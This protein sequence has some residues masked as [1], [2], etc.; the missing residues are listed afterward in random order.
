MKTLLADL[1][2]DA[3]VILDGGWGTQLYAAGLPAGECP[4]LWNLSHAECVA[5]V[6]RGYVAA[7]SRIILT[8]T[9]RANRIALASYDAAAQAVEINRAGASIS[10]AAAGN[11]ARV[12]GSIGPCGKMLIAREVTEDEVLNAFTEQAR[13]LADAGVDGIVI[14]TMSSLAEAKLA[15]AAARATDLPVVACMVFDSGK[16]KDRTM[17]GETPEQ[18]AAELSAAGA[19]AIGANCG[20]GIDHYIA[21]CRRFH[22]AT[23]KPLWIKPNAGLPEFSHGTVTYRTDAATFAARARVLA[24][25]GAHFIGGC[26][27]TTPEFIQALLRAVERG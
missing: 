9:F 19:D 10:R 25:E 8:N 4:D 13:A 6:A 7:G 11:Q 27:G 5:D 21:I 16:D 18:A 26:C 12:F 22:A 2:K 3:P 15:L 1:V 14:E 17:M 24:A 20:V 23:D